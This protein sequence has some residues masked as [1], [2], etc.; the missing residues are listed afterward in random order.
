LSSQQQLVYIDTNVFAILLLTHPNSQD[1]CVKQATNFI[2]DIVN[3]KY[4]GITST[5]TTE[6]EFRAVAKRKISEKKERQVSIQEEQT[7]MQNLNNFIAT[8]GIGLV[9]ADV[10]APDAYGRLRIFAAAGDTVRMSKPIPANKGKWKMIRSVDCLMINIAIRIGAELFATFDGGFREWINP[11]ITPL[12]IS[13][14][15]YA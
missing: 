1:P 14:V 2:Q 8:R 9:N 5:L 15:Y 4:I 3:G 7:A 12:I 10:I 6:I 11:R 13:D